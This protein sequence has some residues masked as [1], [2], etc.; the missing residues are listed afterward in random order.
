MLVASGGVSVVVVAGVLVAGGVGSVVVGGVLLL[1]LVV[2]RLVGGGSSVWCDSGCD[3]DSLSQSE[4]MRSSE[5][6]PLA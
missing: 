6:G 2:T 5:S 1:V 3:S 4:K